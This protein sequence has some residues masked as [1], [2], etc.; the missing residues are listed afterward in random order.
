MQK[1]S[2]VLADDALPAWAIIDGEGEAISLSAAD[3]L[4]YSRVETDR[5]VRPATDYTKDVMDFYL[6]GEKISGVK[7]PWGI[8]DNK[9][10]LRK[11]EVT[12]LSGTNGSG[13]SLL[14]SQWILGAMEQGSK[15]LSISLEMSPKAQLARMWR[16][17][18]LMVEPTINYGLGFNLWTKG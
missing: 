2:A 13:K 3:L 15:C 5:K 9:F 8:L 11:E 16:Q 4:A 7:L 12:V 6:S 1:Q 10:R 17:G 14:A 18:S